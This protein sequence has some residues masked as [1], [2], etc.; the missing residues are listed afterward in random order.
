MT[1]LTTLVRARGVGK[2]FGAGAMATKVLDAVSLEV[3][4]GELTL[5]MGPSGSGKTT[6][7]CILSGL[8][9]PSEGEVELC[10]VAISRLPERAAAEVRRHHVGFVFQ[11]YNLFPALTALDNVAEVLALKG[12]PRPQA[13]EIARDA[14]V[15]VGLGDRLHHQPGQLSGGERQ[16]VAIARALAG[17]PALIFGDEP[18]AALDRHTGM[19]VVGLLKEQV[20]PRRGVMLVTHDLRLTQFADRVI[21]IDDGHLVGDRHPSADPELSATP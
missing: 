17:D 12:T 3:R 21:D 18:T 6:L 10:G 4:G 5:L 19:D 20:T 9:R 14:L 1:A 8:L 15:R 11:S 16:R 2:T 13:R 7:L